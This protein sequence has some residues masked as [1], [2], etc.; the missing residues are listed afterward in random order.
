[1]P[2]SLP[3]TA[4]TVSM[5]RTRSTHPKNRPRNTSPS[6]KI[7]PTSPRKRICTQV[8]CHKPSRSNRPSHTKIMLLSNKEAA[9][10]CHLKALSLNNTRIK[11]KP[12]FRRWILVYERGPSYF[13][14]DT[15][16]INQRV[17]TFV[18]CGSRTSLT[19]LA[20]HIGVWCLHM[21][22]L[23]ALGL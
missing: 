18:S 7:V 22:F 12:T 10:I 17:T 19:L 20:C 11:H 8:T 21:G 5:T 3:V 14:T 23:F 4:R 1:M 13:F 6:N 16:H 9:V 15:R 2:P